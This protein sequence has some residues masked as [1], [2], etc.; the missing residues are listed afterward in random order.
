M[1][2]NKITP[3]TDF[4]EGV[5]INVDKPYGWTS[6]DVV[7]KLKFLLSKIS[8]HK[9]LK[10]GHAGTLDPLATGV[11][12]VCVG[13]ATKQ[14]DALQAERK[15][16]VA[17]VM[18]GATTPSYD[19]EHPVDATYPWEHITPEMVEQALRELT[20]ERL[21]TPPIYSAKKFEGRHA[22][23][24][25]REGESLE[26]ERRQVLINIYNI[27]VVEMALPRLVIRVECSKGT[28]IR[29]LAR[30]IGEQLQSGAHLTALRRTCSG[31]H[32]VEEAFQLDDLLKKL[33][34]MK[35]NLANNVI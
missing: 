20:G 34:E 30:E 25:A 31:T 35:Q 2:Y 33:Q 21:Q 17:E 11:L 7:R 27:E 19:L 12:L 5:V 13:K 26:M 28:Y 23:D 24:F 18:L 15:E 14:A 9:K 6:A 32:T 1:E 29:S 16:Y 10:V 3:D 8:G 22:Y 4:T